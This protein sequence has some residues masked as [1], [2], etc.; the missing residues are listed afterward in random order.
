M[1]EFVSRILSQSKELRVG[2]ERDNQGMPESVSHILSQSKELRA[3]SER[4]KHGM[5]ESASQTLP[6]SNESSMGVKPDLTYTKHDPNQYRDI[7]NF[8]KS[9]MPPMTHL[10]DAFIDFGCINVDFLR[11][12]SSWSFEAIRG[13]LD[14]LGSNGKQLT[15]MEKFILQNH[16]KEY[17]TQLEKRRDSM[18]K[19]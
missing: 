18:H 11:A 7:H 16:F 2:S 12:V 17:F 6:R 1:P 4:D 15:E 3:G 14:Q 8:L 19:L 13:V 9:S 10:M 5:P